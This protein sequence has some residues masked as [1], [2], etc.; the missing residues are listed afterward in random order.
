MS[1]Q[2]E[3]VTDNV[4]RSFGAGG[5]A[6]P[7][8]RVD[9]LGDFHIVREVG[10]GGMGIVYEAEQESLGRRVAL[11]VLLT[12]ALR[13]QRQH[14]R[15]EREAKAA[16]RLHHT[17][18]VPVFG[19]GEH[20]GLHYYVM[21]FIDGPSL[22]RVLA[23]LRHLPQPQTESFPRPAGAPAADA[24]AVEVART[25]MT[26]SMH[27]EHP[28]RDAKT[29]MVV[30]PGADR[31]PR[32][33]AA[34][35]GSEV[36]R[37]SLST[38]RS[39]QSGRTPPVATSG[40]GRSYWQRVARIG[41]QV[42]EALDHAHGQGILHRDIKPSNL[43][44][45]EQGTVWVTDFGLAKA[46][47]GDNLTESGDILGTLRYMA[48]ERFHG[49]CDARSDLF[50][51]GLTLYELLVQR[52]AFE[53][54]D[55]HKLINQIAHGEPVPLRQVNPAIPR[56]LETIVLK[57]IDREPARRYQTARALADDL[58]RFLDDRPI[59]AR[60][61]TLRERLVRWCRRNPVIA[62]LAA[63]V[64][65]L[66][67]VVA[68]ASALAAD[69][70]RTLAERERQAKEDAEKAGQDAEAARKEAEQNAETIKQ[71][72]ARLNAADAKIESARTL[73]DHGQ[74]AKALAEL[75]QALALQPDYARVWVERSNIFARLDL[76]E[77]TARDLK[78][79]FDLQPSADL[80]LWLRHACLRLLVD[81]EAGY[82]QVSKQML[83]RFGTADDPLTASL[84]ARTCTL[85]PGGA[86][87]A[88]VV[89]TVEKAAEKSGK[90]PA[91]KT[92]GFNPVL[93]HALG[94]AH[95]RAGQYD[96]V[97]RD[98]STSYAWQGYFLSTPFYAIAYHH[99]GDKNM[100]QMQLKRTLEWFDQVT[101]NLPRGAMG[102]P[103]GVQPTDWFAF[104]VLSREAQLLITGKADERPKLWAARGYA[105][106]ALGEWAKAEKN[107]TRAIEGNPKEPRYWFERGH[108]RLELKQGPPVDEDLAQAVTL[109]PKDTALLLDRARLYAE[110][111]RWDRAE[112][113][114]TKLIAASPTDLP[115]ALE[116]AR[117]N[118]RDGRTDLAARA[119]VQI[120]Q[121][122]PKDLATV[123][124]ELIAWDP[125]LT[126]V[127]TM[128]PDDLK[129]QLELHRALAR[130]GKLG[131]AEAMLGKAIA[132]KPADL[133]LLWDRGF[134]HARR[135][136]WDQAGADFAK[137]FAARE[138][139]DPRK[140]LAHGLL[141]LQLRDEAGYRR[142]S[143]AFLEAFAHSDDA[144]AT[145]LAVILAL[146]RRRDPQDA[147]PLVDLAERAKPKAVYPW[148]YLAAALAQYRA[149]QY[150]KAVGALPT[151]FPADL[152]AAPRASLGLLHALARFGLGQNEARSWLEKATAALDQEVARDAQS[153]PDWQE[154]LIALTL[155][156]EAEGV[157][158]APDRLAAEKCLQA[159]DWAGA[160]TH[161]DR[162]LQ[163][164]PNCGPDLLT[165]GRA[166]ARLGQWDEAARDF[167][168]AMD[169]LPMEMAGGAFFWSARY[170]V[171]DELARWQPAFA[172]A[173][174][175]RPNDPGLR[176]AHAHLHVRAG[177]WS[178]AAA[179]YEAVLDHLPPHDMMEYAGVLV[180]A[181]DRAG[182]ERVCKMIIARDD[183]D[184]FT[185][186][187]L[188][189]VCGLAAKAPA[190]PRKVIAWAETA[191]RS[192]TPA[193]AWLQNALALAHFRAGDA[194]HAVN[195]CAMSLKQNWGD[196]HVQNWLLLALAHHQLGHVKEA[197]NSF[198]MAAAHLGKFGPETTDAAGRFP[199]SFHPADWIEALILYREAQ[200]F[201][202][203][204]R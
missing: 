39:G 101:A 71:T 118:A 117:L 155:R 36:S 150:Q 200:A 55:R 113:D 139:D 85:A 147:P 67:V 69:H 141:R 89:A 86:D 127:V 137:A 23:E 77:E 63:T 20:G 54:K 158:N 15:F 123:C 119:Y 138:P 68:V 191:I 7:P 21:Q 12:T 129:L 14:Q 29:E 2:R 51:L 100:A 44:L 62:G 204:K 174:A 74:W 172:A 40:S 122:Y 180:L 156:T 41:I 9:R 4:T 173:V 26:G 115:L 154:W 142:V 24:P 73:A 163:A 82:R 135:G 18:I 42:A 107:W 160:I 104:Q 192:Q 8:P 162:L 49:R 197:R 157:L 171:C 70:F 3:P 143:D 84:V 130:E 188:A 136:Q 170:S 103:P 94:I 169:Q 161:V 140:W 146:L 151:A 114:F 38:S 61:V 189:R 31:M 16:A 95:L 33:T 98:F 99:Q 165:R 116:W 183:G 19:M 199:P 102:P 66:L 108:A 202:Q 149:G 133:Q 148:G 88:R 181:D 6:A 80:Y 167:L 198:D 87:P 110:H 164:D 195:D 187:V 182:Y 125:V 177:R 120:L 145:E 159:H 132:A 72:A 78:R 186:F 65:T 184:P 124:N 47:D 111:K 175:L 83:D 52:P 97:V 30:P 46:A 153:G 185:A 58:E 91:G 43:L 10:R 179:D 131:L 17:N 57:S 105:H 112:A 25:L 90:G 60:R 190:E 126:R 11:K 37:V 53:E 92:V 152:K 79:A 201:L 76:P 144:T 35:A 75:D 166:H 34:L 176:L 121:A 45:D 28:D 32:D 56:D 93:Q 27:R 203:K 196:A 106:A 193:S 22:D 50:S 134:L 1:E 5:T 64:A 178:Q 48:P 109:A 59:R 96:L 128:R 81:D 168:K 194:G 13:D